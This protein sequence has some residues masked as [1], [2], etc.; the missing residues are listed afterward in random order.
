MNEATKL[1]LAQNYANRIYTGNMRVEDL[2]LVIEQLH[3]KEPVDIAEMV[4][5]TMNYYAENLS[6]QEQRTNEVVQ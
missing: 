1:A 2:P 5:R 6:E 4:E 3:T